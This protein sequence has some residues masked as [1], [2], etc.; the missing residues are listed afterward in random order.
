M[1]PC[2]VVM[3]G[4]SG[5]ISLLPGDVLQPL[6][7]E[8]RRRDGT[9]RDR[10]QQ[11]GVVVRCDAVRAEGTAPLA[12]VD[13]GPLAMPAHPH[14][15]GLHVP[16]AVGGPVAGLDIDMQAVQAVW[17][18]VAVA[19]TRALGDHLAAA[20]LAGKDIV[21]GVCLIVSFFK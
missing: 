6:D 21:T 13:H 15:D 12:A 1:A 20:V 2:P 4:S 7:R 18:V 14:R 19:G 11:H 9:H 8:R 16:S 10:H 5:L 3:Q 17:T